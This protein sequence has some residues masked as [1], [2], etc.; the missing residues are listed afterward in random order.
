MR[1]NNISR[2]IPVLVYHSGLETQR[3][4]TPSTRLGEG[5]LNSLATETMADCFADSPHLYQTLHNRT[6]LVIDHLSDATSVRETL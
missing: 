1:F 5:V 2:N 3:D 6:E 4:Q